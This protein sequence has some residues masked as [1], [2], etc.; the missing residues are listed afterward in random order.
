MT[1]KECPKCGSTNIDE[2]GLLHGGTATG[3]DLHLT[4]ISNKSGFVGKLCKTKSF[5][6]L[7]CRYVEIYADEKSFDKFK[8]K[9][10]K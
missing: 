9:L 8:E 10:S 2:G 1:M 4:H 5:M 6:C 3:G 7:N